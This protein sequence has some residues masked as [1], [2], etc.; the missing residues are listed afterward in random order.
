MAYVKPQV[1]VF[2]EFTIVPTEITE[3]LRAHISGPNAILHRYLDVSEKALSGLGAYNSA[4]D[5]NYAYPQRRA[6]SKVD[7]AYVKLFADNALLRYLEHTTASA[8][9]VIRAVAG[10]RNWVEAVEANEAG[11]PLYFKANGTFE[12]SGAFYERD[13]KIGDVVRLRGVVDSGETCVEKIL[14]TSVAG[15]ASETVASVINAAVMDSGNESDFNSES[16]NEVLD[17]A[18]ISGPVN[19]VAILDID[20]SEYDGLVDGAL[21]ETYTIEVINSSVAG[22]TG[23]RMRVRST[24]SLDDVAELNPGNIGDEIVI[25]ARGLKVTFSALSSPGCIA[26][27]AAADIIASNFVI[28]QKWSITIRQD[29]T[30]VRAKSNISGNYTGNY[31]DTYILECVKGGYISGAGEGDTPPQVSVRTTKGLD[32]AAP[33][34]VTSSGTAAGNYFPVGQYGVSVAFVADIDGTSPVTTMVKGDKWYVSV[35]ASTAGAVNKLILRDNLPADMLELSSLDMSLF[36]KDDI[37]ISENRLNTTSGVNYELEATQIVVKSGVTAFHPEWT[38][39]GT[40]LPL[41]VSRGQLYLE[42]REWV[43]D[44]CDTVESISSVGDLNVIPGQ[45]DPDNPLKWGVFK[46][47]SNSN[48]TAVK[49]TGVCEPDDLD[50]WGEV[51]ERLKGRDDL[52]NLVPMTFNKQVQS[53]YAAHINN[54]SNE[55]ANNWKAGFFGIQSNSTR[56]VV[57]EGAA[58]DGVSG[59]VSDVVLATVSDNDSASG[60]QFTLLLVEENNSYFITNGVVPGDIVRYGF[61]VN[62]FGE[63]TYSEY[64]VDEV[65]SENSLLLYTGTGAPVTEAE[66]VEVWHNLS[67][68]EMADDIASQAGAW[69]SRRIC[70]IWPDQVGSAGRLQPGYYL[71]AALGGLVSGVVPHQGMTNVEVA[72][73]DDYTRSYK[74]FNETQLNRMA[75]AGVWI[76]TEDRDGTPFTRHGLTTDNLDLNRREEMIRRNVDSLAYL[77]LRRLRPYIGRTNATPGMVDYILN[78]VNEILDFLATSGYTAELGAQ[79]ISGEIRVLRIHPLLKDRIEVVLD[80]VVPA[81][82]NNIELH[83]VV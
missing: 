30:K 45:L 10:K 76:V 78:R 33:F 65:L 55:I 77:F 21:T 59:N 28:G 53:L 18:Q 15:F 72:G 74:M 12:R 68:T 71:A 50:S 7:S 58:I 36:I 4:V 23:T 81:P 25:G 57:G 62:G 67:R 60:D 73:F 39:A 44:L 24:S 82:L 17:S 22:C 79:L 34:E 32:Y 51:L 8:D 11:S 70:A 42:Y 6:G 26:S 35:V 37:Q 40:A 64:V 75:E 54:E 1:L 66:R 5:T 31:N 20:V 41:P 38:D 61:A 48:G 29:F 9:T 43:A 2:Q 3:P 69:G 19:C 27:A 52:Y 49:Y 46:A 56:L 13:V 83:L 14:E 80:L 16:G 47:L 63:T